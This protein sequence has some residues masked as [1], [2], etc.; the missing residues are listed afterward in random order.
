MPNSPGWTRTNNPP[1]NSRM[2]CQLSYRG[3][4]L[5]RADCSRGLREIRRSRSA[6]V[7]AVPGAP[8]SARGR[9]SASSRRSF[10]LAQAQ[11]QLLG[12]LLVDPL[13][14]RARVELG[15]QRNE[16]IVRPRL[17]RA[18]AREPGGAAR[19]R[20][21]R[22]RARRAARAAAGCADARPRAHR[23]RAGRPPRAASA[24]DLPGRRARL[25]RGDEAGLRLAW[26]GRA[27]RRRAA[28]PPGARANPRNRAQDLLHADEGLLP[29]GRA[30]ELEPH[31]VGRRS[32]PARRAAASNRSASVG[33][34]ASRAA[35]RRRGRRTP[36]PAASSIPR[37]VAASPAASASKQ[38]YALARQPRRAPSAAAR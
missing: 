26:A 36:A 22:A 13:G 14:G 21:G 30:L 3:T 33:R 27:G 20:S 23:A 31:A 8:S 28:T 15:Q 5:G 1:V 2:L 34:V 24:S 18:G 11:Q 12:R 25:C 19:R 16:L 35:A 4:A 37:S 38:R 29:V 17:A 6:A 7:R 9:R 10:A 32:S